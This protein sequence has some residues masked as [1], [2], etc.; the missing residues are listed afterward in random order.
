MG[1]TLGIKTC[2]VGLVSELLF[3]LFASGDDADLPLSSL[4]FRTSSNP[5]KT[6]KEPDNFC[7]SRFLE[8]RCSHLPS[9]CAH[10]VLT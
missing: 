4:V 6:R 3:Q 9:V 1:W 10:D 5:A 8:K 7:L 2:F